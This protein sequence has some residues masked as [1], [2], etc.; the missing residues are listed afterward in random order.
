MSSSTGS[1]MVRGI[2]V[3]V[4]ALKCSS[5]GGS[6]LY[7]S[8]TSLSTRFRH[9]DTEPPDRGYTDCVLLQVP[10]KVKVSNEIGDGWCSFN[11]GDNEIITKKKFAYAICADLELVLDQSP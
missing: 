8:G 3:A 11:L 4:T 10:I 5:S 7:P 6:N 1:T 2:V 9:V